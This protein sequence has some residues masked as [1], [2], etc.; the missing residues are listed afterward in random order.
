MLVNGMARRSSISRR[1][2]EL[3]A[4]MRRIVDI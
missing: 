2:F 4:K 3:E 1:Y